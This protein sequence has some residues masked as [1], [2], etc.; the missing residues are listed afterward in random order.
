MDQPDNETIAWIVTGVVS[1]VG[2]AVAAIKRA[3][4]RL[5]TGAKV[6]TLAE[7]LDHDHREMHT[8]LRSSL[9]E[10]ANEWRDQSATLGDVRDI[11]LQVRS[12][13][14]ENS[15]RLDDHRDRIMSL[16]QHR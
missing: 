10:I 2:A 12:R 5:S 11:V 6:D 15:R 13:A 7:K 3:K 8:M 4:V 1:A 16:E 14:E 9:L